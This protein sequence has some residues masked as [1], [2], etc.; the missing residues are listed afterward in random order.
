M[1]LTWLGVPAGA[2]SSLSDSS[3][4]SETSSGFLALLAG[5]MA[6]PLT[7]GVTH[8]AFPGVGA[9]LLLGDS[10]A[11]A[12]EALTCGGFTAGFTWNKTMESEDNPLHP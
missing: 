2:P 1:G 5:V 3:L 7:W 12:A 8:P 9:A 11:A 6:P 4:L 10:L